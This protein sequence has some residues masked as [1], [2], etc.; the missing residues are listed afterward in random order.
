[1]IGRDIVLAKKTGARIYITHLSTSGA[2]DMIRAAKADGV[3]ISCDVTAHHQAEL[4]F[5]VEQLHVGRLL[6]RV[7]RPTEAG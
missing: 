7:V 3:D 6:N 5:I 4:H 1:M 2:V